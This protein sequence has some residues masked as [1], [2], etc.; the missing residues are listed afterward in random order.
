MNR[1]GLA[2]VSAASG[3]SEIALFASTRPKRLRPHAISF[4]ICRRD[5]RKFAPLSVIARSTCDEAIQI[6]ARL[7]IASLRSQ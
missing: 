3:L 7:W 6:L 4:A 5:F 2:A 1:A